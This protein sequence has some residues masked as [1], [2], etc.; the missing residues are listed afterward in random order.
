MGL[1]DAVLTAAIQSL[2]PATKLHHQMAEKL[3]R[4]QEGDDEVRA[5]LVQL[6][7]DQSEAVRTKVFGMHCLT[8]ASGKGCDQGSAVDFVTHTYSHAQIHTINN[9]HTHT[10]ARTLMHKHTRNIRRILWLC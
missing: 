8:L 9:V 1:R 6:L 10:C 2:P 4:I 5:A 3:S 7:N